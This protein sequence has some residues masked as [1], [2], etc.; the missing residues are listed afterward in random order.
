MQVLAGLEPPLDLSTKIFGHDV[1]L[2]FFTCPTA[3][4]NCDNLKIFM[5]VLEHVCL[6]NKMFHME[7]EAG[8]ARAAAKYNSLYCLSSLSTTTIE[9]I[10]T[11]LPPDHPKLFQIYVW[12][13]QST[14]LNCLELIL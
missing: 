1:S 2:P 6:G 4:N 8:V 5:N 3:G 13:V 11:I 10:A 9:E 7:G 14:I 12:K